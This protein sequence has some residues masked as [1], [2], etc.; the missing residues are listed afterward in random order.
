MSSARVCLSGSLWVEEE[1]PTVSPHIE[2]PNQL[3]KINHGPIY[4]I[5]LNFTQKKSWFHG[6]IEHV[7]NDESNFQ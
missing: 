1:E 4:E 7:I 2:N 5:F 6:K 3:L